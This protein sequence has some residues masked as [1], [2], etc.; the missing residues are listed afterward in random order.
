MKRQVFD[1]DESNSFYF[2]SAAWPST[3]E[4]QTPQTHVPEISFHD[5]DL[6][7][8]EIKAKQIEVALHPDNPNYQT[9]E[10]YWCG[11][12]VTKAHSV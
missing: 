9:D 10:Y 1:I 3:Q 11:I 4:I 7:V 2:L 8:L 5:K 12:L 6:T